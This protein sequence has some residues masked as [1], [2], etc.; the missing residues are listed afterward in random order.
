MIKTGLY[1]YRERQIHQWNRLKDPEINPYTYGHLIFDQEAKT[2]PWAKKK[3]PSTNG[4]GV[5]DG[6]HVQECQLIHIYHYAQDSH[7]SGSR[8]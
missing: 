1:A 4:A 7:P 5:T 2:I 8:T 6:L 3:A